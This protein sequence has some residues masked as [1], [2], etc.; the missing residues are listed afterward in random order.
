M[1]AVV[2]DELNHQ[3]QELD[4]KGFDIMRRQGVARKNVRI[5]RSAQIR[6]IGQTYEVE[7]PVPG[8]K[9]DSGALEKIVL[10]FHK[11]HAKEY[12]FSE[13]KFPAAFVNLRSTAIGKVDKPQIAGI[14]DENTDPASEAL[15]RRHVFFDD[16]DFVKTAVYDRQRLPAGFRV[17]GPAILEDAS[18]TALIAPDMHGEVDAYGNVLVTLR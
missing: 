11:A 13:E 7:T 2:L 12:G 10:G 5:T 15:E 1:A 3:Y 18:A 4:Q 14:K 6:Y 16:H 9:I 17:G 8:G